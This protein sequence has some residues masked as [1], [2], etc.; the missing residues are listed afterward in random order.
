L[1]QSLEKSPCGKILGLELVLFKFAGSIGTG[2]VA[3]EVDGELVQD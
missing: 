3:D 1:A 2:G